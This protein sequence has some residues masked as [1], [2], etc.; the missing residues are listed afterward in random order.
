[1]LAV[2]A[3]A[4]GDSGLQLRLVLVLVPEL[5]PLL[6]V[7]HRQSRMLKLRAPCR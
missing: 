4:Q 3:L 7:A 6:P 1:M 2:V 5:P